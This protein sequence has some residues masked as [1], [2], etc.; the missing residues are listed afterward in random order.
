[1]DVM[2]QEYGGGGGMS[3]G[4][5]VGDDISNS[6]P[7]ITCMQIRSATP[8]NNTKDLDSLLGALN[9]S[10]ERL[11]TLWFSFLGLTLYFIITALTTTH[12]NLLLEEAQTLPIIN[13]K[14]PLLPFYVIAPLFYLVLHFYVLMML[15]LLARSASVFE[16]ALQK[17]VPKTV[18][19]EQLRM[20]AENTLFLQ[21]LIGADEER[22]GRNGQLL[23]TI[24]MITLAIAPVVTL[25]IMQLQFL[26]YHHFAITWLHRAVIAVDVVLI[27]LL[28]RGYRYRQGSALP[29]GVVESWQA[30]RPGWFDRGA[31]VFTGIVVVMWLSLW[32]GRWAGEPWLDPVA[33]E[34]RRLLIN[35]GVYSDRLGL[36]NETIIG[37]LLLL[38]KQKEAASGDSDRQVPTRN[39]RGRNFAYADFSSA[40]LRGVSFGRDPKTETSTVL[41]GADL[42][43]ALLNGAD[44]SYVR[45]QGANLQGAQIQGALFIATQIQGAYFA[46]ARMQGALF[47]ST[48]MQG[49]NL[50]GT[51]MQGA[52]FASVDMQG[53]YLSRAQMQGTVLRGIRMQG[54]DLRLAQMQGAEITNA[55]VFRTITSTSNLTD[56]WFQDLE[57]GK[58]QP[59]DQLEPVPM[60]DSD[61][62]EWIVTATA[63][64]RLD[65]LAAS[66]IE[67]FNRLRGDYTETDQAVAENWQSFQ[68][69]AQANDPDGSK[70][71]ATLATLYSDLAC[72]G[73]ANAPHVARRL[74]EP[75][76]IFEVPA[77]AR[78]GD[79][80][81]IVRNRMKTGRSDAS[82]CPGVTGFTESDWKRLDAI[83]PNPQTNVRSLEK[84]N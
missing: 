39:F 57:F 65:Y 71:R 58:M 69:A 64:L 51:E 26:P 18:E 46:N 6:M 28:W 74:S 80:L 9:R 52:V 63:S 61:I 21:L 34:E 83:K 41:Q 23:A 82:K 31:N 25:I 13:L 36:S 43:Q 15:L 72:E 53:A 3:R 44:L 7:H 79:Y 5:G 48:A 45:M 29:N 49:A 81:D 30:R 2:G 56:V 20:R 47:Y 38:E 50:S 66:V 77:L 8:E 37:E 11:Q 76:G 84:F 68:F 24:A 55:Y 10:A 1:M 14:V 35:T 40:D 59:G 17:A 12:R 75:V 33:G 4:D 19:R 42:S 70:R 73:G 27:L 54:A 16:N 60:L 78:L 32:E 67:G 62:E 22:T